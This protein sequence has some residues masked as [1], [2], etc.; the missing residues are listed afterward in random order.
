MPSITPN[1]WFDTESLEAAECYVSVFPNAKITNITYD[2]ERTGTT[3]HRRCSG[4]CWRINVD[5]SIDSC[6]LKTDFDT[7]QNLLGTSA[8]QA[9]E[10]PVRAV[11][12]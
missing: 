1:L 8:E 12:C 11:S 9:R 3:R 4:V 7:L 5:L 6:E 10:V 2:N